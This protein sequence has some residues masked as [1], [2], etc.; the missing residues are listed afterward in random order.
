LT[1]G[2]LPTGLC[3]LLTAGE[4]SRELCPLLAPVRRTTEMKILSPV[5][6]A[7]V[8]PAGE[9]GRVKSGGEKRSGYSRGRSERTPCRY[10]ESTSRITVI[11][12]RYSVFGVCLPSAV[13][14]TPPLECLRLQSSRGTLYRL[15]GE[16]GKTTRPSRPGRFHPEPLTDPCVTVSSHTA[17][18]TH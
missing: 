17:R 10:R 6:S 14:E 3:P 8:L 5:R 15:P 18:A 11:C 7:G 2:E 13:H 12:R 9:L 4:L 16:Q 1:A